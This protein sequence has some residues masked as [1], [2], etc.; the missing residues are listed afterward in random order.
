M[1]K[2]IKESADQ[3]LDAKGNYKDIFTGLIWLVIPLIIIYFLFF[4]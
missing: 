1:I 3:K 4:A 2:K